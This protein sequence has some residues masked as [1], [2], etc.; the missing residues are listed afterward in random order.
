MA[1]LVGR[2]GFIY[3]SPLFRILFILVLSIALY[4]D[5]PDDRWPTLGPRFVDA[6][7]YGAIHSTDHRCRRTVRDLID[8]ISNHMIFLRV[9]S[10]SL[11]KFFRFFKNL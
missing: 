4:F 2:G 7:F 9:Y 11:I 3:G 10:I 8:L 1:R 6:P 5:I